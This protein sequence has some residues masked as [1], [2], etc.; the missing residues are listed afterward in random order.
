MLCV[1]PL[2][3]PG[4]WAILADTTG[5]DWGM[6]NISN[7]TRYVVPVIIFTSAFLGWSL[8][9]VTLQR[10][11]GWFYSTYKLNLIDLR[12]F[13][14]YQCVHRAGFLNQVTDDCIY[15]Y[16]VVLPH[17]FH[18]PVSPHLPVSKVLWKITSSGRN[19]RPLRNFPW[20]NPL[21]WQF[22]EEAVHLWCADISLLGNKAR[23]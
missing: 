8:L 14:C 11:M 1:F 7:S 16:S 4:C 15:C 19:Q 22:S 10:G 23:L 20:S 18:S 21:I 13:C 17:A 6:W 12:K 3:F 9:A 2:L 5:A